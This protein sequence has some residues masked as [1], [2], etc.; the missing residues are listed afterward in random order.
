[1]ITVVKRDP[2]GKE[3]IRYYGDHPQRLANGIVIEADWTQAARDLGYTRFETGDHF[4]EYYYTDR[5]FNIFDIYS[6]SGIRK[7][8]YCNIAEPALIFEQQIEQKD[9]LLDVWIS[10]QGEPLILDEEEFT[11]YQGLSAEQRAGAQQ[12][13]HELLQLLATQQEAFSSLANYH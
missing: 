3:L 8:W 12:G 13:L 2:Q 4:T 6:Q 10:P 7:G 9:L 11:S 1:M 5:W